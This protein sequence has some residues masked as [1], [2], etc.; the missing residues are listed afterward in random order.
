MIPQANDNTA[1]INDNLYTFNI[2]LDNGTSQVGLNFAAI[3]ELNIID[4]LKYFYVYGTL[5]VN[6]TNDVLEAFG[7]VDPDLVHALTISTNN[8]PY[9]F[10]GDGRDVLLIDIMPQ[11][12]EQSCL[13]NY[14]SEGD[15]LVHNIKHT[16]IIYKYEDITTGGGNKTRKFYFW[17]RD[18]QVM[19]DVNINFSTSDKTKDTGSIFTT[20]NNQSLNVA[21]SNTDGSMFTG[22]A[23][24]TIIKTALELDASGIVFEKGRWDVGQSKIFY[25]SS[26]K[27]KAINDLTYVLQYHIS[28]VSDFNMPCL[29]KKERYTDKY[30]LVPINQYYKAGAG[31]N[32][33]TLGSTGTQS[34]AGLTEDFYIGKIDPSSTLKSGSINALVTDYNLIDDYTFIRIDAKDLQKY[35][36]TYVVHS[37]DPR[38]FFNSDLKENNIVNA[39]K[40]YEDVFVKSINA[41]SATTNLPKNKVREDN[42]N[43]QHTYVPESMDKNQRKSFGVNMGM[44]NLFFKNTSITFRSRGLTARKAGNLFTVNRRD[45]NV[46]NTYDNNVLGK[47]VITYIRHEF[48]KGTY[49]NTVHGVKPYT[50]QNPNLRDI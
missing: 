9:Q 32:L 43:V 48:G 39:K 1:V 5:S 29:L 45:G 24:E 15:K 38:G 34:K 46:S 33:A 20:L 37:N 41:G 7:D 8:K 16:C 35:M 21:R 13:Q 49:N 31:F 30:E 12:K 47:Y 17:D 10:R 3:Q 2:I 4:D 28:G 11:L 36:A 6:Y 19:N 25:Y 40:V 50:E 42:I 27:N 23:I 18:Y 22:D 44:L 14:T 26:A